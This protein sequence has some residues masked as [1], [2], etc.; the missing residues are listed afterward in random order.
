[1]NVFVDALSNLRNGPEASKA[2]APTPPV[3][4]PRRPDIRTT[5]V[6]GSGAM[7]P[8]T[9]RDALGTIA[10]PASVKPDTK[11]SQPANNIL[12]EP[13]PSSPRPEPKELPPIPNSLQ[14][15]A[16]KIAEQ[17]VGEGRE[18]KRWE[19]I[20]PNTQEALTLLSNGIEG[21]ISKLPPE[22][23]Q[24][25]RDQV[26][27]TIDS[28]DVVRR[29]FNMAVVNATPSNE[30]AAGRTGLQEGF[31]QV[32]ENMKGILLSLLVI[33]KIS[34]LESTHALGYPGSNITNL[35]R[36]QAIYQEG[37]SDELL[38]EFTNSLKQ[39]GNASLQTAAYQLA[40]LL[41]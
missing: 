34:S 40:S 12:R 21:T 9:A 23:R 27:K 18:Y 15:T 22:R 35:T 19:D 1:M 14:G 24:E 8:D 38:R 28:V 33:D 2:K 41:L 4:P 17:Y 10:S 13:L 5:N 7:R 6:A 31:R 30:T 39:T 16:R 36:I 26:Y 37:K 25:T 20:P 32:P 3:Q 11:I 29:S